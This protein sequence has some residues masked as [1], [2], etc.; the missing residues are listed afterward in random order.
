L[1][2][3]LFATNSWAATYY[4]DCS[5]GSDA[6]NGTSK[7]TAWAH[8]PGMTGTVNGVGP[9]AID[10]YNGSGGMSCG[11]GTCSLPGYE[12]IFKG[13]VT[14]GV[15]S[16]AGGGLPWVMR[17][18]GTGSVI[19]TS[20]V[21]FGVDE[22]WY[23]GSSWTRPILN[24]GGSTGN[25]CGTSATPSTNCHP[26][27]QFSPTG[28]AIFDNLEFTGLYWN[29]GSPG[30]GGNDIES[31]IA[32]GNCNSLGH[33][34]LKNLYLHGWSHAPYSSGA[35]A[36][37]CDLIGGD[38]QG[39]D[40]TSSL[41]DSVIDGSDTAGDACVGVWG[42]PP[43]VY[44]TVFKNLPNGAIVNYPLLWHDNLFDTINSSYDTTQHNQAFEDNGSSSNMYWYNNVVRN[45]TNCNG[46]TVNF[47]PWPGVTTYVFNNVIYNTNDTPLNVQAEHSGSGGTLLVE[48]NTIE[49]GAD[50]VVGTGNSSNGGV[51]QNG[52]YPGC[53]RGMAGCVYRNN[54]FIGNNNQSTQTCQATCTNTTN[55][56]QTKSV[57]NRQGYAISQTFAFSPS[58]SSN[59]TVGM[60]TALTLSWPSGFSTNDTT[61]ACTDGSG[62]Q[63]SCPARITVGRPSTGVWDAG[64]YRSFSPAP[65]QNLKDVVH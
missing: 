20:A 29:T 32:M 65:A 22:T 41:H 63:P 15:G 3:L 27:V 11:G 35:N 36:D 4:I 25:L 10:I 30:P 28:Y 54:H 46:L 51:L 21:Y 62:N 57:A 26:V 24:A 23:A 7:T 13:G 52:T 45:T 59:S 39:I 17:E 14:C 38:T 37:V 2:L 16:G 5:A 19:G 49:L 53:P 18:K 12:F 8:A 50:S 33:C 64:A 6:N 9:G 48:N 1:A 60:G 34:E 43:I 42:D 61:Y 56:S 58:Q 31:Y 40:T 55:L 44:D 47:A